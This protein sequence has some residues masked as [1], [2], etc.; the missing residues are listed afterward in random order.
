MELSIVMEESLSGQAFTGRKSS[1][2]LL[3]LSLR[4]RAEISGRHTE[5]RV[6]TWESKGERRKAV[7]CHPHIND[8]RYNV[9]I[10][11]SR[12]TVYREKWRG[13]R[14]EPWGS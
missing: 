8:R 2:V 5:M 3:S 12:M 10:R 7:E 14:T 11:W 6:A 13:P 4:R 1:S 9:Q